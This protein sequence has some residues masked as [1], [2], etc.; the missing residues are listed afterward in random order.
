MSKSV[1]IKVKD[2]VFDN[3]A[4]VAFIAGPCAMESEALLR[5]VGRG[6]KR[7][8]SKLGLPFVLKCSFDKANR[9]SIDSYRG[10]GAEKGL[11]IL[12]KIGGELGVPTI[13]DVH[14]AA[15]AALAA[16]YVDILQIPAFLCRQTDLLIACGRTGKPINVKKGQFMAP[17]DMRN[18]ARKIESTG[19]RRIL[20]TERG[21]TFG[22]GN[23]VV[24][25]R[26]L[27]IMR[28][29]GYPV[30]YDATHSVQLPGA[31]G[32]AT[33]GQRQYAIP[34]SRAAVA[35]GVAGLFLETHPDPEQALSDGPNSVR[36]RD[37]PQLVRQMRMIDSL[38]K[39]VKINGGRTEPVR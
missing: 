17:W 3:R 11:Q 1:R 10:L 36:L 28:G 7:E 16:R 25:M 31:L 30:I 2:V 27:E 18:A 19:N 22:Y 9:S 12:A 13:S 5:R 35:V 8:F 20:L 29:F 39:K 37:V 38:V 26:S 4:P 33:G 24:D 32:H 14:E 21:T 6:L 34:L 15:Q 23:L